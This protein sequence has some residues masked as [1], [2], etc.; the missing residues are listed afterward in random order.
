MKFFDFNIKFL[1]KNW[2]NLFH[3]IIDFSYKC[4]SSS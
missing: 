1:L 4:D 2:Y 3:N